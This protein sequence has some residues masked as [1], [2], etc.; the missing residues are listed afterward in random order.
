MHVHSYLQSAVTIL[1]LYDGNIPFAAWLKNYFKQ[2]K[3]FGSK[4][5]KA[6][7]DLCFCFFRL[8]NAFAEKSIQ[9]RISIGQFLCHANSPFVNELKPEWQPFL[10]LSIPEKLKAI[11]ADEDIA[12]SPFS[13]ELSPEIE[14][15]TFSL[16]HLVQ[17]DLF[18]RTRPGKQETVIQKL[19]AGAV[20]FTIESDCV[21][22]ANTSKIDDILELDSDVVVQDKSSQQ[23]LNPL[24]ENWNKDSFTAWD[25]CAASGGKTILLHDIFPKAQLTVSDIRE[26]ILHNLR[27]RFRRAGIHQYQS[28]V[29]DVSASSFRSNRK[30]DVIICDAPCSGSGTWGRTPEQ[31]HFFKHDRID[32]YADLQKRIAANA[33]KSLNKDGM[34]VY[35][36]CSVFK[37]EN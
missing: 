4:D 6:I 7:G 10:A 3:K 19:N 14:N 11:N 37:K 1:Q 26:S 13:Q 23:V 12:I 5:R 36:T 28:F 30:Y 35:I 27:S 32:Y 31:L 29:A 24:K 22:L 18:L 8:S 21:R 33:S 25:C 15:G 34:F 20:S 16:S 9:E 17:P 2:N